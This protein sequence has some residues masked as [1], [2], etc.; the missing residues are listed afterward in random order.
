[1]AGIGDVPTISLAELEATGPRLEVLDRLRPAA[2]DLGAF[3]LE[4][5]EG[6]RRAAAEI[7]ALCTRLFRLPAADLAAIE[8]LNSPYFR[9]YNRAGSELTRSR[10]DLREQLDLAPER[11]PRELAADDPA[12]WR[13]QGP[14][15]WPGSLPELRPAMTSWMERCRA[16]AEVVLGALLASLE[17]EAGAL[18]GGFT[19]DPHTRLKILHYP[20][21]EEGAPDQGVGEHRDSGAITIIVQDGSEGLQVARGGRFI[22]IRARP[23]TVVV[24][25]GRT[26]EYATR[27]YFVAAPHRVVNPPLGTERHSVTYFYSPRLDYVVPQLVLPPAFAG[28]AR[29]EVLADSEAVDAEYGLSA[30]EVLLRS[31]PDVARRHHPDL[32]ARR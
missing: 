4:V 11:A 18:A 10:P 29:P 20:G 24:L 25:L 19:P 28:G 26:L 22:D 14:N 13:L 6:D 5:G 3:L 21:V 8:M 32:P 23:A 15:Q 9:G 7:L 27:G 30:L 2:H 16:I 17:T 1:M 12:Y 31:H